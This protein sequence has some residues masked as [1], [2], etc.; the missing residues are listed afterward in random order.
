M[1]K[2]GGRGGSLLYTKVSTDRRP[3]S[4]TFSQNSKGGFPGAPEKT[5]I[6]D[7]DKGLRGTPFRLLV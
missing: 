1:V 5:G 2:K 7:T 6:L 3:L 4:R